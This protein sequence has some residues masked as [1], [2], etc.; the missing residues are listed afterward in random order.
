MCL[1]VYDY[2]LTQ[3][4]LV[5]GMLMHTL[6]LG[7]LAFRML[8]QF[9]ETPEVLFPCDMVSIAQSLVYIYTMYTL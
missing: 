8:V 9:W 5:F 4:A 3:S 2:A 7:V 1:T 6:T